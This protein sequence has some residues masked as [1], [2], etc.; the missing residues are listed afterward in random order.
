M[1]S[2][3]ESLNDGKMC[4]SVIPAD[5]VGD[6][7]SRKDLEWYDDINEEKYNLKVIFNILIIFHTIIGKG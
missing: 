5:L 3:L 7:I 6:L 1:G 4:D 2:D